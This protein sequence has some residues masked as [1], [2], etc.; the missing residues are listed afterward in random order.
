MA[1]INVWIRMKKQ[2]EKKANIAALQ[3]TWIAAKNAKHRFQETLLEADIA[4]ALE[5]WLQNARTTFEDRGTISNYYAYIIDLLQKGILSNNPTSTD[6][7]RI[8]ELNNAYDEIIERINDFEGFK[9]NDRRYRVKALLAFT[10]FLSDETGSAVK[11]LIAPPVLMSTD[12]LPKLNNASSKP[13]V[14]SKGEFQKI[15]DVIRNPR[16]RDFSNNRDY[17]VIQ[18][19]YLTARSLL[20]VLALQKEN[21][22]TSNNIIIFSSSSTNPIAVHINKKLSSNLKVYLDYS[23]ENR[24]DECVF[25]TREGN[26]IFRTHFYQVLKHASE[27]TGL[28][29]TPT[30]KMIQWAYVAERIEIDKS[31]EKVMKELNLKKIPKNIESRA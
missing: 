20:D 16:Q 26:P 21:I 14:L 15:S 22:D 27:V 1:G 7:F 31:A 11:K 30:F 12:N 17:L 4:Q 6:Y 10:K 3:S 18:I 13:L 25:I 29:F 28:G 9:I 19:M 8:S 2:D 24:K 23:R 5:F